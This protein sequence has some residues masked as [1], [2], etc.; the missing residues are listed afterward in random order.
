MVAFKNLKN[1]KGD[2]LQ[3]GKSG[4]CTVSIGLYSNS[5]K[6]YLSV[7][8]YTNFMSE[9]VE[10]QFINFVKSKFENISIEVKK[11]DVLNMSKYV[12]DRKKEDLV[13]NIFDNIESIFNTRSSK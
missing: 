1:N 2:I 8:D 6:L 12:V 3:T 10:V 9:L 13:L 11:D 4:F 7:L 5:D